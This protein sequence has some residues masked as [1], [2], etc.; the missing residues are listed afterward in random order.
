M[1]NFDLFR[2]KTVSSIEFRLYREQYRRNSK[3][4][5]DQV[6]LVNVGQ[7]EIEEFGRPCF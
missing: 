2:K 4:K 1:L 5:L 6:S 3:R 7:R